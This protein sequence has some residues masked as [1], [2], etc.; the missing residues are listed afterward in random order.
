MHRPDQ[1]APDLHANGRIALLKILPLPVQS[2]LFRGTRRGQGW[3]WV[4]QAESADSKPWYVARK[5][6]RYLNKLLLGAILVFEVL[7]TQKRR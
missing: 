4:E 2:I 1:R 7:F 5:P 6:T 3:T